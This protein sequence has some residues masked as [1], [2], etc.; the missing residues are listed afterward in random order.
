[1]AGVIGLG[2]EDQRK[3]EALFKKLEKATPRQARAL[4]R[5]AAELLS[6]SAKAEEEPASPL[7][8]HQE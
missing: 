6:P 5:Q 1:M 3:L 4:L 2:E 7:D 8:P